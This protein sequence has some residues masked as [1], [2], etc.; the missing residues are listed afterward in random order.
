MNIQDQLVSFDL[1]KKLKE[2]GVSVESYFFYS[3]EADFSLAHC[4]MRTRK[5]DD[6]SAF[7][8]SELVA[9][10][11]ED[12]SLRFYEGRWYIEASGLKVA[13]DS[14]LVNAVA[15]FMIRLIELKHLKEQKI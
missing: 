11:E 10:I 15:D 2:L 14:S 8:V 9:E 13:N 6:I 4:F 5:S 1:A 3:K 7:T 12:I